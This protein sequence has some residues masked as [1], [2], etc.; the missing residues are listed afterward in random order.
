MSVA[1]RVA[2]ILWGIWFK[3]GDPL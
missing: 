2:S 3:N 1:A